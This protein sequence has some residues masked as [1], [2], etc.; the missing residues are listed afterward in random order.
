MRLHTHN[1]ISAAFV[2]RFPEAGKL[3]SVSA[4]SAQGQLE[5]V[6]AAGFRPFSAVSGALKIVKASNHFFVAG[7]LVQGGDLVE[8]EENVAKRLI[9][10]GQAVAATDEDI[11]ESQK[12]AKAK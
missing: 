5:T 4:A 10:N 1:S 6:Q 12:P 11:A 8:V 2:A 9:A 7:S 3:E